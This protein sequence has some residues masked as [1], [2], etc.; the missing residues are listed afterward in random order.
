[1]VEDLETRVENID[2]D[3]LVSALSSDMIRP[4]DAKHKVG[5]LK[6]NITSNLESYLKERGVF[7]T[8]RDKSSFG[9]TLYG[10]IRKKPLKQV[11]YG[12][13]NSENVPNE[14]FESLTD[15][16]AIYFLAGV[17]IK[18]ATPI[19]DL[20]YDVSLL[21]RQPTELIIAET[22]VAGINRLRKIHEQE[23]YNSEVHLP[24]SEEILQRYHNIRAKFIAQSRKKGKPPK[25]K[26]ETLF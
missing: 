15:W 9:E 3:S 6:Y 11:Q 24:Y 16:E 19:K 17:W 20:K 25:P 1:M 21:R 22:I 5:R 18:K 10:T 4:K 26:Q 7:L 12:M 8:E 2:K 14:V 23:G 13:I